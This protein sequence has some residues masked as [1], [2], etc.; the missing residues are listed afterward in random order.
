[1]RWA[2][3]RSSRSSC[4]GGRRADGPGGAALCDAPRRA[5]RRG[6]DDG[7]E[8]NS[9]RSLHYVDYK[10]KGKLSTG[11]RSTSAILHAAKKVCDTLPRRAPEEWQLV[12]L[13]GRQEGPL[14]GALACEGADRYG[15][16]SARSRR[17]PNCVEARACLPDR[18]PKVGSLAGRQ[19]PDAPPAG[20]KASVW[21]VSF[22]RRTQMRPSSMS[23]S[24]IPQGAC[25]RRQ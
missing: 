6:V 16:S 2:G 3:G 5:R 13:N 9:P 23:I 17:L 4:Q 19:R 24:L 1:M 21:A 15:S 22:T 10:V 18:F 7:K 25:A 11:S 12:A 20:I 14:V 8:R